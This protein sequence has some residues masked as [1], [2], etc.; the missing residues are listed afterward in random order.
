MPQ[1][2]DKSSRAS[3]E[4]PSSLRISRL[5]KEYKPSK[6]YRK[7]HPHHLTHRGT[8]R[9]VD[10]ICLEALAGEVTVLLGANGAGKTTTLECAQG[11]QKPESGEIHLLGHNPW[12]ASAELRARVGIMLQDGGLPQSLR[13]IPLLEHIAAMY[14]QTYPLDELIQRLGI[15]TFN[16]TNIRRLS[17]GE[18]QRVAFAAALIGKPEILFLDEPSAGLDP[19]SRQVVFDLIT[20]QKNRGTAIVLTTHLL[21]DAQRLADYVYII[22]AGRNVLEGT[23]PELVEQSTT[24]VKTLH[25]SL[26]D[27]SLSITQLLPTSSKG[28]SLSTAYPGSYTLTGEI[29]PRILAE[30]TASLA[31]R[32]LLPQ[33]MELSSRTLEDVF[34]D[35]AGKET[36]SS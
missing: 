8:V 1:D 33:R 25:F 23:V 13:P 16:G 4:K 18:R 24:D 11:I 22:G 9:A 3:D 30:L 34:L 21:D 29:T 12:G 35:I 36:S 5:V 19:H 10:G 2:R 27:D 32:Q 15:D 31:A 17:G 14:Q 7:K 20:E 6:S 26:S 28:L